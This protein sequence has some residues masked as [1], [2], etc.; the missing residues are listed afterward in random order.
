MSTCGSRKHCDPN[1]RELNDCLANCATHEMAFV[2]GFDKSLKR[3]RP[4]NWTMLGFAHVK[5]YHEYSSMVREHS[6]MIRLSL[7]AP[8]SALST[9]APSSF[10]IESSNSY[11]SIGKI[12]V[13]FCQALQ[14]REPLKS[15]VRSAELSRITASSLKQLDGRYVCPRRLAEQNEPK[16]QGV[17]R[18]VARP[19]ANSSVSQHVVKQ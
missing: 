7:L 17:K 15:R 9:V 14:A 18:V 11:D 12:F 3:P 1:T 19:P 4:D 10:I 6:R 5:I 13:K 8:P 16:I 2:F